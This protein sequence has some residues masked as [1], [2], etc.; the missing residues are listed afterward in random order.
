MPVLPLFA[1]GFVIKLESD[2]LLG[3]IIKSYFPLVIAILIA[4]LV[5]ISFYILP[6]L[7]LILK[8]LIF[9]RNVLPA[10]M[11]GFSTM[12]SMAALPLSL[13]AAEK[14]RTSRF[15]KNYCSCNG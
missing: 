11:M 1:L 9:M 15:I 4:E 6:Q 14:Y 13:H 10:G 3:V 7:V 5:Y 12:S 8:V 2:G